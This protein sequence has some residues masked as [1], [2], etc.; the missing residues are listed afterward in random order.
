MTD[1]NNTEAL[2]TLG[3]LYADNIIAQPS[4]AIKLLSRAIELRP[5]HKEA[6]LSLAKVY[7]VEGRCR[8]AME[9]LDE[10]LSEDAEKILNAC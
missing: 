4:K 1:A 6:R 5:T 2:F 8:E 7:A 9:V 10:T 3:Q